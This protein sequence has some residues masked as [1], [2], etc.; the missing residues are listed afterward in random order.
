VGESN[1]S[2]FAIKEGELLGSTDSHEP[3][4]TTTM[5]AFLETCDGFG[6]G[7]VTVEEFEALLHHTEVTFEFAEAKVAALTVPETP[8]EVPEDRRA[9]AESCQEI[10]TATLESFHEGVAQCRQALE[11]FRSCLDKPQPA[12][13]APVGDGILIYF[14]GC[15][16]LIRVGYLFERFLNLVKDDNA[17]LE[18]AAAEADA[19]PSEPEG[20]L[21]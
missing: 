5:L 15:Q 6:V 18:A 9:L 16:K 14:A 11:L 7:K 10:S 2:S 19:G 3:V 21:A 17:A 13:M 20:Q 12:R 4:M 8:S 1:A